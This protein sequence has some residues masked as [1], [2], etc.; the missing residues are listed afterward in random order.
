MHQTEAI[1]WCSNQRL[2]QWLCVHDSIVQFLYKYW[3]LSLCS[4][5]LKAKKNPS[6]FI[7]RSEARNFRRGLYIYFLNT[8]LQ[9]IHA[10]LRTCSRESQRQTVASTLRY[11]YA[12][13]SDLTRDCVLALMLL[14]APATVQ[15]GHG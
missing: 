12:V 8:E 10:Q 13:P 4:F 7:K 9:S 5:R 2:Q 15:G 11:S 6:G 1:Y 14:F 3:L